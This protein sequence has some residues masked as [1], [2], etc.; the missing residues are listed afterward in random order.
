MLAKTR[1]ADWVWAGVAGMTVA[2]FITWLGHLDVIMQGVVAGTPLALFLGVAQH[3]GDSRDQDIYTYIIVVCQVSSLVMAV[4]IRY[5][6][7]TLEQHWAVASGGG[8]AA[9]VAIIAA[10]LFTAPP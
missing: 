2:I 9:C 4:V 3:S 8:L 5:L 1:P 6:A 10:I 7:V